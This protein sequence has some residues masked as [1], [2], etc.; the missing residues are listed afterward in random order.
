MRVEGAIL[1]AGNGSRVNREAW[2]GLID[3]RPELRR[4]QPWQAINPFTREP[5]VVRPS[6]DVA[7]V[8]VDGMAVGDASWS[9]SE[10]EPLVNVSVQRSALP[11]VLQ[12][13]AEL[14]GEF[15]EEQA[16]AEA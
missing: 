4:P 8:V 1:P 5:M 2:C 11:L 12:W 3:S 9:M 16:R 14:G 10:D 6:D 13:A 7:E 15:R